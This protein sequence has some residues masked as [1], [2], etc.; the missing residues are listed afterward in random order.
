M[1]MKLMTGLCAIIALAACGSPDPEAQKEK[2]LRAKKDAVNVEFNDAKMAE[3]IVGFRAAPVSTVR[4]AGAD[5][6]SGQRAKNVGAD[7]K[8]ASKGYA[9]EFR[10][11]TTVNL[12]SFGRET[13][14]ITMTCAYNDKTFTETFKAENLSKSSR[15]GGAF[16]VG[17]L[18][19]PVCGV[20]AGVAGSGDKLGDAYGF[21]ELEM[22]LD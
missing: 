12:P 8:I 6:S 10:T 11:P 22:S 5:F 17:V 4:G 19:C 18:L 21:A 2:H 15:T 7:C 9:A 14:P 16:A 1:Q 13:P 3:K 20:A